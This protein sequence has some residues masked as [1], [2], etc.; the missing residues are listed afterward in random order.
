MTEKLAIQI[1]VVQARGAWRG[2]RDT[3]ERRRRDQHR[4]SVDKE[5]HNDHSRMEQQVKSSD[6]QYQSAR[7]WS[8]ILTVDREEGHEQG[9]RVIWIDEYTNE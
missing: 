8:V 5:S 4:M 1:D 2:R 7:I 9:K 3:Q 6:M